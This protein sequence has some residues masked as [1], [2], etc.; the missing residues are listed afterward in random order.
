MCVI[1]NKFGRLNE[2]WRVRPAAS[3]MRRGQVPTLRRVDVGCSLTPSTSIASRDCSTLHICFDSVEPYTMS[4]KVAVSG[5]KSL[6][7]NW[8]SNNQPTTSSQSSDTPPAASRNIAPAKKTLTDTEKRLKAIQAALDGQAV[9]GESHAHT[10]SAGQKRPAPTVL[11]SNTANKKRQLPSS[12][13]EE[14]MTSQR[15]TQN[16]RTMSSSSNRNVESES[17]TT[18][19]MSSSGKSAAKPAPVFLSQEQTHILKL[20]ENGES[21]FYTGSAGAHYH[22]PCLVLRSNVHNE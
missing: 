15:S 19:T 20:V 21:L 9:P 14:N 6:K 11:G 5:I 4:T 2:P 12:W 22:C 16:S 8:S 7:R 13:N 10:A 17:V 18:L 3:K 1:I